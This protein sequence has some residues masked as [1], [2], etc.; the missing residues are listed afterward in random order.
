MCS[1]SQF[2]IGNL[3]ETERVVR[4][5]QSAGCAAGGFPAGL[6]WEVRLGCLR[7][8][9]GLDGHCHVSLRVYTLDIIKNK[10]KQLVAIVVLVGTTPP[11][12]SSRTT[13][14]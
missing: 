10:I 5:T 4:S 2:D 3:T 9:A 11:P 12:L 1:E 14:I 7:V 13:T 8:V 6:G